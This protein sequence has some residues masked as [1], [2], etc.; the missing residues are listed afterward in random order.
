MTGLLSPQV[1]QIL[2]S[3][4]LDERS[5]SEDS[6]PSQNRK[7]RARSAKQDNNI[8]KIQTSPLPRGSKR[9]QAEPPPQLHRPG[10]NSEKHP[11]IARFHSLRSILFSTRIEDN[12]QKSNE[13]RMKADAESKWKA[14]HEQRKGLQ[15]PKT[16]EAQ[17]PPKEGL[18]NKIRGGL[19][20][21]A[22]KD[23][24]PPMKKIQEDENV[25]TASDEDDEKMVE[26]KQN[27]SDSEID[28]SDI[29][30]LV[31][32]VSRKDPPSDGERSK[33][34]AGLNPI[35]KHD[36]SHESLAH[37]DVEE[38]V[39]WVSRRD[40]LQQEERDGHYGYSDAPTESDSEGEPRGRKR[41]ESMDQDDI[42]ELVRWV[43]H[44]DGPKAGPVLKKKGQ[45]TTESTESTDDLMRW[46]TMKDD[47]SGESEPESQE[48]LATMDKPT[49]KLTIPSEGGSKL[50]KEVYR[51][52]S[53][54]RGLN[55]EAQLTHDD[56]DDLVRW[57]SR[58]N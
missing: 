42:D 47:T 58:K 1:T 34:N 26:N 27:S 23:S 33:T 9:V 16:P 29:E 10:L 57:V 17:T 15:R 21:M 50:K 54:T 3:L 43:S 12:I 48:N 6:D 13:A 46:V 55:S 45:P 53:P 28:H 20:R 5:S 7:P 31:R 30:D 41:E 49:K 19:K 2:D 4:Q 18:V 32:W 56:V 22:S 38:L 8:R 14:E 24:P 39:R 25:S 35:A 51:D 36:G 37:S 52:K 40:G 44:K 11:H